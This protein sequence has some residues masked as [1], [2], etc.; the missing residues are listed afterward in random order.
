MKRRIR[1]PKRRKRP[2]EVSG[3]WPLEKVAR[4][5]CLSVPTVWAAE[6]SALAKI[7]AALEVEQ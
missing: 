1:Y 5:M 2:A 3:V 7:R 6:R 4:A